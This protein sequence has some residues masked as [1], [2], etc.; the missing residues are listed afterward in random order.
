MTTSLMQ[1]PRY[2]GFFWP[3]TLLCQSF[4]NFMNHIN[5]TD[6]L[7]IIA[8]SWYKDRHFVRVFKNPGGVTMYLN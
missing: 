1:S 8:I 2:H 3:E 4:F 5:M 6:P 7:N